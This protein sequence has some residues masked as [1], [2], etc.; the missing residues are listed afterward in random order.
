MTSQGRPH[1]SHN[2]SNGILVDAVPRRYGTDKGTGATGSRWKKFSSANDLPYPPCGG[3]FMGVPVIGKYT[4]N[5]RWQSAV[6]GYGVQLPVAQLSSAAVLKPLDQESCWKPSI[7]VGCCWMLTLTACFSNQASLLVVPQSGKL[8]ELSL[9]TVVT[10][11][12]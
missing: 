5:S 12:L 2:T 3:R 10:P 7:A 11:W 6:Y 9:I 8:R 1:D 4:H